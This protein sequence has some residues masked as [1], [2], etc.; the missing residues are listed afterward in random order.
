IARLSLRF[1]E[2]EEDVGERVTLSTLHGSKG[3]EFGLV[4]LVG[5]DEGLLPH[6]R[7]DTPKA[8]DILSTIDPN[9]ERRLF[10]V[11]VTRAKER[12]YLLRARQRQARGS[13][14]TTAPSRFLADIPAHLL[15]RKTYVANAPLSTA[16]LA[17]Q[18]R[19]ALDA[20]AALKQHKAAGGGGKR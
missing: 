8:T 5:C 3:L 17:V 20:L 14:R 10:S 6:S 11:G 2:E 19:A 9:E 1:G 12:L 7:T 4:F 16:E 13:L 18:A 15:E